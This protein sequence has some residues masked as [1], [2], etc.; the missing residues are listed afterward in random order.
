MKYIEKIFNFSRL[1]HPDTL[2]VL[3]SDP[4]YVSPEGGS[5]EG[6]STAL[7]APLSAVFGAHHRSGSS[8]SAAPERRQPRGV[9]T[10]RRISLAKTSI[11]SSYPTALVVALAVSRFLCRLFRLLALGLLSAKWSFDTHWGHCCMLL[12]GDCQY[13][14]IVHVFLS[15]FSI[16]H[17]QEILVT[18]VL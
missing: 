5:S 11:T 9:P 18:I 13:G 10:L 6:S 14:M 4:N 16:H 12:A 1:T 15:R 8:R 17:C 2:T 3:I 7:R